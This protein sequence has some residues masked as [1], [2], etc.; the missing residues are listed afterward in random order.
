MFNFLL[1]LITEK[2]RGIHAYSAVAK[3]A[4]ERTLSEPEHAAAFYFLASSAENFVEM[5]ERQPL[6]SKALEQNFEAFRADIQALEASLNGSI[7]KRLSV[8]NEVVK[9]HVERTQ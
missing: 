5:H 2:G 4:F 7:E 6:S 8:L 3:A 1:D 9:A